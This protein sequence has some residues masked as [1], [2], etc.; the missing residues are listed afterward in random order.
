MNLF[1]GHGRVPPRASGLARLGQP[2]GP[3]HADATGSMAAVLAREGPHP[4]VSPETR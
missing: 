2:L 1:V 3:R 4:R